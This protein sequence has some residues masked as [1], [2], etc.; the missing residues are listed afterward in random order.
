MDL[1]KDMKKYIT[2]V[3]LLVLFIGLLGFF[4]F[5]ESGKEDK[6]EMDDYEVKNFI[7]WEFNRNDIKTIDLEYDQKILKIKKLE[8]GSYKITEPFEIEAEENKISTILDSLSF[9]EGKG[10]EISYE[11][12]DDFGLVE[13]SVKVNIKLEDGSEREIIF[14]DESIEGMEVYAKVSD[15]DYIF[16][17]DKILLGNLMIEEEDLKEKEQGSKSSVSPKDSVGEE[18]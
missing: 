14:G 17:I 5:F 3:I 2:T 7:V 11:K 8:D 6:E 16:L 10:E 9:I 12:L 13:P 1:I 4:Y 15:K 18:K